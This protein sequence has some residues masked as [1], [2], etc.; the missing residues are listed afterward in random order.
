MHD[1]VA[2]LSEA[3]LTRNVHLMEFQGIV[4]KW[5]AD[6]QQKVETLE[7][8]RNKDRDR[9]AGLEQRLARVQ[10]EL[11]WVATTIP[12][13]TTPARRAQPIQ[14]P[15]PPTTRLVLGSPM[16]GGTQQR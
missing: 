12:L 13:P 2:F 11:L 5:A 10:V 7:Q 15:G 9:M 3:N 6:H 8:Q 16:L 14:S 4:E 1:V